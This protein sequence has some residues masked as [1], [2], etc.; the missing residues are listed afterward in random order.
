MAPNTN[1]SIPNVFLPIYIASFVATQIGFSISVEQCIFQP[2]L[3]SVGIG[4][5]IAIIQQA[6]AGVIA[7]R[8]FLQ[9][10]LIWNV[11]KKYFLFFLSAPSVVIFPDYTNEYH[12][13]VSTQ[14]R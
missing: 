7:S 12:S 8:E 3:A 2:L 13:Y 11:N 6:I 5:S 9:D 1:M 4:F 10:R 14:K